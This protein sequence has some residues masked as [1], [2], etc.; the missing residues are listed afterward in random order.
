MEYDEFIDRVQERLNLDSRDDAIRITEVTLATL[1]ERLDRLERDQTAA[2][3]PNELKAFLLKAS[4][5]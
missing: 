5:S 1:G 2:Q 3:L 4:W